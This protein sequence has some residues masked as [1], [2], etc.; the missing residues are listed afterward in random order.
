M[1]GKIFVT[2]ATGNVGGE[3]AW[4]LLQAGE[5]VLAGYRSDEGG[6]ALR[7]LGAETVRF[8]YR[9]KKT[10]N[11]A[12]EGVDRVFLVSPPADPEAPER[13]APFIEAVKASDVRLIVDL[14]AMGADA[15]PSSP[16]FRIEEHIRFTGV[17]HVILRPN[18]FMQNLKGFLFA[19]IVKQ[20][21]IFAPAGEGQTSFVDVRDIAD[22]A[23]KAFREPGHEGN[24]YVLT[25]PR[26]LSYG[27]VAQILRL[28]SGCDVSYVPLSEED[29]REGLLDAGWPEDSV[30][31]LLFLFKY[32]REGATAGVSADVKQVL[33]RA[34][35]SLEKFARDYA[36]LFRECVAG[37]EA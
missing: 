32:V 7:A 36:N 16:L 5:S 11:R 12:L 27:D 2:G 31:Y 34:P 37:A 15:D 30:D 18:W 35:R 9:D 14:S 24:V 19:G 22:V 26:A 8:D 28:A 17:E 13:V 1:D 25:G 29:A 20:G 33:G 23:V 10:F 6:S 4:R 3:V 21:G